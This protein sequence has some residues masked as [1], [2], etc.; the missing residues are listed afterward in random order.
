MAEADTGEADGDAELA[1]PL[2]TVCFI[3]EKAH[4]LQGKTA[5]SLYEDET[6]DS[7]N[8]EAEILED[9]SADP[10]MIELESVISDLPVDAQTDLVALMWLGRDEEDW[11]ELRALAEQERTGATAAYLC[12]TPLLADYLLAGLN[13]LGLDCTGLEGRT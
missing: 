4:D 3:I 7:D 11:Q 2:S 12:G 6:G 9:R 13:T 8:L 1:V 5:S 10:V